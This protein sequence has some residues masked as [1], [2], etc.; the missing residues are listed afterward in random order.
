MLN[1]DEIDPDPEGI[2]RGLTRLALAVAA[3]AAPAAR[4]VVPVP[5]PRVRVSAEVPLS[6][7]ARLM[8]LATERGI[9]LDDAVSRALTEPGWLAPDVIDGSARPVTSEDQPATHGGQG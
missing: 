2:A 6:L 7:A 8:A 9:G 1:T 4:P 5:C 3:P